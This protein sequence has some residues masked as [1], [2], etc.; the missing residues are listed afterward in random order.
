MQ[1]TRVWPPLSSGCGHVGSSGLSKALVVRWVSQLLE[2]YFRLLKWSVATTLT[3]GEQKEC[4][5]AWCG[6]QGL[7]LPRDPLSALF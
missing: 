1:L 6:A 4:R 7:P 2:T 5:M 3:M